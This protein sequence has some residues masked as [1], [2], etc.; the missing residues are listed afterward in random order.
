MLGEAQ[1][2]WVG[3]VI[4]GAGG[5][6]LTVCESA[7]VFIPGNWETEI[8]NEGQGYLVELAAAG[9]TAPKAAMTG[10]STFRIK[11]GDDGFYQDSPDV[12]Q[13]SS[14]GDLHRARTKAP[15]VSY[16]GDNF[17][18]MLSVLNKARTYMPGCQ[19]RHLR[20][21]APV[22]G[23]TWYV[24]YCCVLIERWYLDIEKLHSASRLSSSH[25]GILS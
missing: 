12:P 9:N 1:H 4:R 25:S 8:T 23:L 14:T 10:S 2:R 11:C 18:S 15:R 24:A 13:Q 17:A 20:L 7:A 22:Q 19:R 16:F 5:W 3:N 6:E 21:N